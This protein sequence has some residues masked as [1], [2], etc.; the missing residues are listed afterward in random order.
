MADIGFAKLQQNELVRAREYF[1]QALKIDPNNGSALLNLA[2]VCEREGK[3]AEAETLYR[4]I[5]ALPSA[6]G[7]GKGKDGTGGGRPIE[8]ACAG[9][10]EASPT[11]QGLEF[12]K[13]GVTVAERKAQ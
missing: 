3:K 11:R 13:R 2:T 5:L 12:V 9:W 4:R 8:S 10:A 6:N 7:N 1:N